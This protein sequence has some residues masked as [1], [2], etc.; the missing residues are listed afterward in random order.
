MEYYIL[1]ELLKGKYCECTKIMTKLNAEELL[2]F[3]ILTFDNCSTVLTITPLYIA[4]P[5]EACVLSD[6]I[7][8]SV[9]H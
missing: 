9:L 5:T 8:R 4:T 7:K 3:G 1:T 2:L 6:I